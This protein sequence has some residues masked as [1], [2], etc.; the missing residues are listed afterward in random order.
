MQA[1]YTRTTTYFVDCAL[2]RAFIGNLYVGWSSN[3]GSSS[4]PSPWNFG[5]LSL[6]ISL[7]NCSSFFQNENYNER[8]AFSCFSCM[9]WVGF[10]GM[11]G[12]PVS[13]AGFFLFPRSG[14]L[15]PQLMMVPS[16]DILECRHLWPEP[17]HVWILEPICH[18]LMAPHQELFE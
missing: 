2:A 9:P 18:H 6:I 14:S 12:D 1:S 8:T 10:R 13:P 16:H 17:A 7:A 4:E 11:V 5:S 15:W 3:L